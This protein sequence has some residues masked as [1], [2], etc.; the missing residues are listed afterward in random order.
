MEQNFVGITGIANSTELDFVSEQFSL[1]NYYLHSVH[2]IPMIGLM[3]TRK[4]GFSEVVGRRNLI[5]NVLK[6][7]VPETSKLALPY[8]YYS[9]DNE[10]NNKQ[11]VSDV[12]TI[13]E[14]ESCGSLYSTL[15]CNSLLINMLNPTIESLDSLKKKFSGLSIGL[16]IFESTIDELSI[17]GL[18]SKIKNYGQLVD[19]II[20]C[21]PKNETLELDTLITTYKKLSDNC[22]KLRLGFDPSFSS[23]NVYGGLH[24]LIK[25]IGHNDFS[26]NINEGIMLKD[27]YNLILHKPF[28]KKYLEGTSMYMGNR[29]R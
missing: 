4:K 1:K 14:S 17:D 5:T 8:I 7:L 19:T 26:I 27:G 24:K 18:V 9:N 21:S 13:F 11:L 22:P 12:T 2:H 16:N 28:V 10:D 20:L 29:V 25:E 6:N 23:E 3:I 15:H